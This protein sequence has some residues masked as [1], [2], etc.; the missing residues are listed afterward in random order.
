MIIHLTALVAGYLPILEA[1]SQILRGLLLCFQNRAPVQWVWE[2]SVAKR[3]KGKNIVCLLYPHS[4][5][6]FLVRLYKRQGRNCDFI[7]DGLVPSMW[8]SK[9]KSLL[10]TVIT[11]AIITK[12]HLLNEI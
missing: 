7:Y 6:L 3:R 1:T 5:A 2:Q 12:T 10:L 8:S 11:L 9:L 4:F